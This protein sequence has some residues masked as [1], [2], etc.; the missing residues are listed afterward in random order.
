M[1]AN[2]CDRSEKLFA[3]EYP[4]CPEEAFATSGRPRFSHI[5]LSRM[6]IIRD[7]IAGELELIHTGTQRKVIFKP[8]ADGRGPLL[9]YRRPEPGKV[10]TIGAD[11]ASGADPNF[12][13]GDEG[14]TDPDFCSAQ[15]IDCS[16]G[17]QVAKIRERWT[18]P[19]FAEWIWMLGQWFN[20]AY[21]VPEANNHGQALIGELLRLNYPLDRIHV[22]RRVPGDR[23]PPML[24]EIG[25]LTNVATRPQLVSG[26]DEAINEM[27]VI[28]RDANTLGECLKFVVWPDG[29]ARAQRGKGNHDDDVLALA[30]GVVGLKFAPRLTREDLSRKTV[31]AQRKDNQ[32]VRYGPFAARQRVAVEDD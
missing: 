4:A 12:R 7:P 3:Q 30:L 21:L 25:F 20:W 2:K 28:I 23:R 31:L 24:N 15:A 18:P 14:E 16:S 13:P 1:I 8:S 9:L 27:S 32:V 19:L 17:E 6:P 26:L 22:K 29:V 10:Y 5:S 11:P